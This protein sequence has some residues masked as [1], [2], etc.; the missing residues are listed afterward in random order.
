[1]V[2]SHSAVHTTHSRSKDTASLFA[3]VGRVVLALPG[4]YAMCQSYPTLRHHGAPPRVSHE[5]SRETEKQK[6]RPPTPGTDVVPGLCRSLCSKGCG[7][8]IVVHGNDV[9]PP[10][11]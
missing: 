9:H 5:V 11:V 10:L 3:R 4:V 1:M 2:G 8:T 7:D 6:H